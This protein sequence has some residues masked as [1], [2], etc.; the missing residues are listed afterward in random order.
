MGHRTKGTGVRQPAAMAGL[1]GDLSRATGAA[2]GNT[3]G[4]LA[5]RR[6][7]TFLLCLGL[8]LAV[9]AAYANHFRNEFHFDDFHT[10]V[11]NLFVT[12]LHNVPR[13]FGDAALFSTIATNAAYRPVASTSL[14]IDYW[15]GHGYQPFFFHLSTFCWFAV[16][17]I[18]MFFLFRRIMDRAD[19]HSSNLWTALAAA[20]CYGLHPA[21]AETVNGNSKQKAGIMD[22]I[23]NCPKC[24]QEL[25]VDSTGAG[26]EI[27][28]PSCGET[29]VIPA[30]ELVANR[31]GVD[32]ASG[33]PSVGVR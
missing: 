30:P 33:A 29:I 23:F 26:T 16:Q 32:N 11:N 10:I 5:I 8:T 1:E 12:D 31:Q 18:L 27:E 6:G 21:N 9:L 22:V 25:A 20:A 19:P 28:C 2:P 14:A 15:L 3:A 13:F 7:R 17:L 24:E 4:T